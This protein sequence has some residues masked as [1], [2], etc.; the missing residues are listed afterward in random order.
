MSSN[1]EKKVVEEVEIEDDDE[2]EEFPVEDWGKAE[3]VPEDRELWGDN[4]DDDD[5]DENFTAQLRAEL[6]E[7]QKDAEMK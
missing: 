7:N 6:E 4:W 2:F 3:E 1:K 5:V